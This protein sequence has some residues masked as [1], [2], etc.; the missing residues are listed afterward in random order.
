MGRT[1]ISLHST[2]RRIS[3]PADKVAV[4]KW[5]EWMEG[6]RGR[7]RRETMNDT[8]ISHDF[9]AYVLDYGLSG[10]TSPPPTRRTP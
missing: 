2:S 7:H 10:A 8:K 1:L 3:T 9:E 5:D 4:V 6:F